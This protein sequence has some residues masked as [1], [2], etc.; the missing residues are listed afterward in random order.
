MYAECEENF[1]GLERNYAYQLG[2]QSEMDGDS[3]LYTDVQLQLIADSTDAIK[4]YKASPLWFKK[5]MNAFAD[6]MASAAA[7]A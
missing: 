4:D 1:K 5:L 2:R 7:S 3:K 6:G